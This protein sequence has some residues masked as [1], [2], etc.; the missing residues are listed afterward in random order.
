MRLHVFNPE[1][2][3]VL[4]HNDKYFTAPH[5]GRQLRADLGFLPVFWA[6][7][8][9]IVLV[10]D[11]PAALLHVGR[12][13]QYAH[14]VIFVEKKDVWKYVDNIE[15]IEPWGW[16]LA[17][18]FQLRQAGIPQHLL[19][20]DD[21]LAVL[22]KLASRHTS[23][24][25]LQR[26]KANVGNKALTGESKYVE[27]LPELKATIAEYGQA[28]L[29]APWSSSGRGIRYVSGEL[30]SLMENWA[31]KVMARQQ[32][33]T[34]EPYYNK[35]KDFAMEFSVVNG[36]VSYCGLSVFYTA[37]SAY[38]G[39]VL[40]GEEDKKA[41]LE[42][43]IDPIVL[44]KVKDAIVCLIGEMLPAGY[45]GAFGVDM[46]VVACH[47]NK[48]TE[49]SGFLLHPMVEINLRRTMGHVALSLSSGST[50]IK[51]VMRID[52]DGSHYRLHIN[53]IR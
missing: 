20:P 41:V 15:A 35:V 27:G 48:Q 2:E 52:Y 42:Q 37:K 47:S 45:C 32:G 17:L 23:A 38:T 10:D 26:L 18:A 46:M 14:R 43:Y 13:S 29:K 31:G 36:K 6:A 33:L 34:V 44:E 19:P 8:G 5:A 22:R 1:H 21:E 11:A 40:T 12:F 28:V 30:D 51:R 49:P 50:D 16:D 3:M 7:D 4:A 39:N 24:A 53:K 9:D 25:V